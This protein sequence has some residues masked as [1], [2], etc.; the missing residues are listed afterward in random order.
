[1]HISL[2]FQKKHVTCNYLNA[3]DI[4]LCVDIVCYT[5]K[6]CGYTLASGI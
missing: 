4:S 5:S 6:L 1:M 3:D 2:H